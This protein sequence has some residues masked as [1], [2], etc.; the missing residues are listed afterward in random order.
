MKSQRKQREGLFFPFV[1]LYFTAKQKGNLDSREQ[2][3]AKRE[4][5]NVVE[6]H[7]DHL[8]KQGFSMRR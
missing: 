2:V 8:Q 6:G 7:Y 3:K 4:V 1:F 5:G